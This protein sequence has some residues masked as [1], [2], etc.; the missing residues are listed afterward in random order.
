MAQTNCNSNRYLLITPFTR[1]APY[2]ITTTNH[3]GHNRDH[4]S[5]KVYH[6]SHM[7]SLFT[8]VKVI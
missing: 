3:D 6:D 5:H 1:C 4:V 2:T 7:Y 8:T